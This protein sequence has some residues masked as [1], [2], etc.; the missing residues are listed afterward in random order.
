MAAI[1]WQESKFGKWMIN[2][3]D[4]SC[5]VFHNLLKSVAKREGKSVSKFSQAR[6]C[7]QLIEDFDFS[8]S[9]SLAELEYWKNYW[10]SKGYKNNELW[11]RTV[12]SYN[13]GFNYKNGKTYLDNIIKKI[14]IL[15][16]YN[17]SNLKF[18]KNF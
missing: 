9:Q 6:I 10:K 14:R 2:L 18:F 13:A 11:R 7:E 4:P 15:K 8:F 16:K 17:I 12:M 5:G 3:S 1:A